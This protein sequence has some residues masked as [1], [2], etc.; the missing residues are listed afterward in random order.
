M[1][2]IKY[3]FLLST[4]A[5]CIVISGLALGG[6]TNK[7]VELTKASLAEVRQNIYVGETDN[8][9]VTFMSGKRE[10]D[11]VINGY[12]TA[13]IPFGVVTVK[14]TNP[15]ITQTEGATFALTVDTNRYEGVFEINPFDGTY[16]GDIKQI[17][18]TDA[19]IT[20]RFV[21]GSLNEEINLTNISKNWQVNY[22]QALEIACN[23]LKPQLKALTNNTFMGETYIKIIHDTKIQDNAYYWLVNF[24]GRK[25]VT[26]SVL[27]NPNTA[28]ILAKK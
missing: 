6:C 9:S 28:E 11:Y 8:L 21:L 13:L 20:L 26:H 12:N 22:E 19:D 2:N 23:E 24:V 16:V 1:K 10:T 3:F 5:C 25:G 14:L 15:N 4:L 7:Y 18:N 27:I 17:V